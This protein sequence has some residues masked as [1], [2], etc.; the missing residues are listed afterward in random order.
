MAAR[1]LGPGRLMAIRDDLGRQF[2]NAATE[3]L[4]IE[5]LM[6]SKLLNADLRIWANRL[7]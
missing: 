7:T 1:G 5:G 2:K 4:G 6:I 3:F